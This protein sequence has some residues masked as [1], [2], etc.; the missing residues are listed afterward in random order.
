MEL[1]TSIIILIILALLCLITIIVDITNIKH[2]QQ[3]CLAD[4][5]KYASYLTGKPCTCGGLIYP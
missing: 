5:L 3:V 1:K 4:P 2:A